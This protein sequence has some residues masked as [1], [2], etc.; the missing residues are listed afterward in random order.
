MIKELVKDVLGQYDAD[1]TGLTDFALASAG[2]SIVSTRNTETYTAGAPWWSLYGVPLCSYAKSPRTI[3]QV[4]SKP[5]YIR[6]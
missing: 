6:G 5:Q 3:I 4:N 2:G 1:K